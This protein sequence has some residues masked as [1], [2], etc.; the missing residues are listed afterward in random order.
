M[1]NAILYSQK[2]YELQVSLGVYNSAE[3]KKIMRN[4]HVEGVI[5]G[6]EYYFNLIDISSQ[7]WQTGYNIDGKSQTSFS[8]KAL[9]R[10]D[11][12]VPGGTVL[13][14]FTMINDEM[15]FEFKLMITL[16][17]LSAVLT[18]RSPHN[19]PLPRS[20]KASGPPVPFVSAANVRSRRIGVT[21]LRVVIKCDGN[22]MG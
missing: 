17:P 21:R 3:H 6:I 15:K 12:S 19:V 11:V 7:A 10:G 8:W 9:P 2:I 22:P 5:N 20:M 18:I 14:P 1:T 4:T 13:I 16:V